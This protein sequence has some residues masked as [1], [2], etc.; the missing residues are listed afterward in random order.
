MKGI[1]GGLLATLALAGNAGAQ[2][3]VNYATRTATAASSAT[4]PATPGQVTSASATLQGSL[5]TSTLSST[6]LNNLVY[7]FIFNIGTSAS[8][9]TNPTACCLLSSASIWMNGHVDDSQLWTSFTAGDYRAYENGYGN[10]FYG[11]R[12]SQGSYDLPYSF[13][14][15]SY[16]VL[17]ETSTPL[18]GQGAG[19]SG[20]AS[21]TATLVGAYVLNSDGSVRNAAT[22]DANGNGWFAAATTTPEP[23]SVALLAPGLI[24]LVPL[25][26]GARR[27]KV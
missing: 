7:R 11:W 23:S 12:N 3:S 20:S 1:I 16:S 18:A 15:N 24:G 17:V 22:F 10:E 19:T 6:D 4:V 25:S 2:A 26:R 9:I 27:R 21:A 14:T 13:V 5:D 8:N